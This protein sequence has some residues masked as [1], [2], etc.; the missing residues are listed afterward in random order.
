MAGPVGISVSRP[1]IHLSQG[2]V[3]VGVIFAAWI[4]WLAVNQKLVVYWLILTGKGGAGTALGNQSTQPPNSVVNNP[5]STTGQPTTGTAT[6]T[7]TNL[8]PFLGPG[9]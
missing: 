6:G 3:V 9:P 1:T 5:L 2:T 7:V 8:V 4:L